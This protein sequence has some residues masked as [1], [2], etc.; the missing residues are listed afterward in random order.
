LLGVLQVQQSHVVR[1]L[2]V[3]MAF[4]CQLVGLAL[5][6]VAMSLAGTSVTTTA[7]LVAMRASVLTAE[8]KWGPFAVVCSSDQ[9]A[10]I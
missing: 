4:V 7:L 5:K 9:Q 3:R 2:N 10:M 6:I 1:A 8:V